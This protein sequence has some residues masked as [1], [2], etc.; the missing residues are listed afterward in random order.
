MHS[1]HI[2]PI[3]AMAALGAC[4]DGTSGNGR[5]DVR[6]LMSQSASASA[7]AAPL[8]DAPL[9]GTLSMDRVARSALDSLN[10]T[11]TSVEALPAASSDTVAADSAGEGKGGWVTLA[12]PAPLV[13]NLLSL[14][15][16]SAAGGLQLVRGDLLPG[17]YRRVRLVVSGGSVVFKQATTVGQAAFAAGQRVPLEVPSGKIK[18]AASFTVGEESV[19][20][21]RLVFDPNATVRDVT[22]TGSGRVKINPV[23]R[24]K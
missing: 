10:V 18:T 13:V 12:L 11:I 20:A 4:V 19:A 14:P 23:L 9:A 17:S 7:S 24:A 1:K 5:A 16:D 3:L 6:V 15:A 8:A 22:V 2:L 21:V